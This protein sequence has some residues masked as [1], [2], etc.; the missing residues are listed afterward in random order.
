MRKVDVKNLVFLMGLLL[1]L[2][3]QGCSS[4]NTAAGVKPENQPPQE[5]KKDEPGPVEP[6]SAKVTEFILGPGDKLD[7]TV[8]RND[9]LKRTIQIDPTGKISFPLVGDIQASGTSIFQLRDRLQ[10]GLAKYIIDPQVTV[11]VVSIQSQKFIVLGEVRNPG[12]FQ[13]DTSV[14]VFEAISRAGGVTND[15]QRKSVLLIRGGMKKP[16]LISLDMEKALKEGDLR[17]NVL[18]QR[19][20]ILYVPRTFISN[21][22]RFF[23]H[24]S[25]IISPVLSIETGYFIGQQIESQRGTT[26]VAP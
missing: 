17:Q 25:T 20:D 6:E 13:A 10:T 14:T 21:V 26:A 18:L 9:D 5:A 1:F 2:A 23:N 7:I 16:E 4:V 19:G 22:D 15:G 11:G 24:L 8:Y 3:V 12:F